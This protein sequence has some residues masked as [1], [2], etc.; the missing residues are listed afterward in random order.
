V[1]GGASV[2][3][4]DAL[5]NVLAERKGDAAAIEALYLRT[6]SRRPSQEEL[7]HWTAFVK[8]PREAVAW[9]PPAP[10]PPKR[11]NNP[12]KAAFVGERRLART[13][14]LVPRQETPRQQA[15]EDVLWA[16]LNSTEFTFN[17]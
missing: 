6:L 5:A 3:P 12:A 8:A 11:G 9:Q 14:R 7:D 15:F 17:H 4:G 10:P 2:I 1:N 13:E 16:L